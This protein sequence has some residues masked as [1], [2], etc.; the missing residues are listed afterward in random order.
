MRCIYQQ[1]KVGESPGL[2]FFQYGNEKGKQGYWDGLKFQDQCN[3]FMNVLEKVHPDMQILLEVDHSSGHL[4][5]Q[6][7]GL[8]V[9]AMGMKWGGKTIP[10]HDTVME[11]GCLGA[12]PPTI[13][14]KKLTLGTVQKMT[15]DV[16]DEGPFYEP[17]AH[18]YD[19]P[20]TPAEIV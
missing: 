8:M 6:S 10:K 9:N 4:K 11:E 16:G 15:F 14:G 19:I 13:N 12:D 18:R 2:I 20:M 7:N 1:L 3:D 5:E 17:S